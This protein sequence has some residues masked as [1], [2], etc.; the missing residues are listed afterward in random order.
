MLKIV[1][2]IGGDNNFSISPHG[3]SIPQFL[4]PTWKSIWQYL[5]YHVPLVI[6]PEATTSCNEMFSPAYYTLRLKRCCTCGNMNAMFSNMNDIWPDLSS[7]TGHR[8]KWSLRDNLLFDR[9]EILRE[10]SM[11][12]C[13]FTGVWISTKYRCTFR[14]GSHT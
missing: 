7:Q 13:D 8:K 2:G 4:F 14:S 5:I 6:C 3:R 10:A 12:S 1:L 9:Y 11:L